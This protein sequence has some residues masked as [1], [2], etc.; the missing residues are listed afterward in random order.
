MT[1]NQHY[2][3]IALSIIGL[4]TV[5]ATPAAFAG[6]T[7]DKVES[8]H[9]LIVATNAD[10]PPQAFLNE[11]NQ[12]DGFD[13]DVAK[14]IGKR[15]GAKVTLA[16]P[17]WEVMTAGKWSGRWQIAVGSITPTKKRLEVLDFPSV[18]YYTPA[19]FAVHKNSTLQKVA[20]LNGKKVGVVSASTYENYLRHQLVVDAA[21]VPAFTYQV[22]PGEIR[23]Y[24]DADDLSDLAIGAGTRLDAVLQAQPTILA[25]IAKGMPIRQLDTPVFYE[26]LAIATDKGDKEFD[27]KIA[28]IVDAMKADGTMKQLSQKWY[29]SDFTS[30]Q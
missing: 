15:L 5:F 1:C 7:L 27:D 20:D 30:A 2:S 13:I 19:V 14:E 23:S 8:S 24:T 9:E 16:T 17:G 29:G 18:Y 3:A 12:L 10:Y 4:F 22:T 26:P 28:S 6:A 25:A 11:N 21:N